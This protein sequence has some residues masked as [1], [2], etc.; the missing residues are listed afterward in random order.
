MPMPRAVAAFLALLLLA[1]CS[2][3]PPAGDATPP[4]NLVDDRGLG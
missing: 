4:D 1:A 2:G 3:S